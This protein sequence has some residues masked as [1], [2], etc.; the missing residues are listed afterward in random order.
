MM[1]PSRARAAGRRLGEVLVDAVN[2]YFADGCG[3]FAAAIAYRVL[4][5][6][7]P[8]AIVLTSVAGV[9]LRNDA[10]R[11]EV[12]DA[13]VDALPVDAAGRQ[14]VEHAIVSIA[15][16]AS[17]VGLISIVAFA[18]TATG[19]MAAFR[20]GL[21]AAMRSPGD[22][23]MVRGK[24]VDLALVMIA[25]LLVMIVVIGS[26]IG[27]AAWASARDRLAP[28]GLETGWLEEI[29]TRG[30]PLALAT[31]IV[32]L[33]YRFVP[34]RRLGTG[35]ALAGA[36]V[37]AVLL[38]GLSLLSARLYQTTLDMSAIYGSLTTLFVFLYTVYLHACAVLLGAEV[39]AAWARWPVRATG[40]PGSGGLMGRVRRIVD[41]I[42][43]RDRGTIEDAPPP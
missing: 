26:A 3:Q 31:G 11:A 19:M 21:A 27:A 33:L 24:L 39:A 25:G 37:T 6:I 41:L 10:R 43:R 4:F 32:L 5:S 30:V 20:A 1:S 7:A 12:V 13:I 15:S 18:W 17:L 9:V 35:D 14:D 38:L 29:V 16:P 23:P 2:G 34:A 40:L 28:L 36:L 8:L 42:R 22:R